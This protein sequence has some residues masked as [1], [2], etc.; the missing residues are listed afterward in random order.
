MHRFLWLDCR[1]LYMSILCF[2][3]YSCPLICYCVFYLCFCFAF[4]FVLSFFA[5]FEYH[6][7]FLEGSRHLLR[8]INFFARLCEGGS[9]IHSSR[10][11]SAP[12]KNCWRRQYCCRIFVVASYFESVSFQHISIGYLIYDIL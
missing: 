8:I 7:C 11:Y 12:D 3:I 9:I 5:S 10:P 6:G 4:C 1:K 2:V